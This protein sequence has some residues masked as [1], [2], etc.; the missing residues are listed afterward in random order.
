MPSQ[1]STG[2]VE[3]KPDKSRK[4]QKTHGDTLK[5]VNFC[6]DTIDKQDIKATVAVQA[7][8]LYDSICI[9][10]L[11]ATGLYL[12]TELFPFNAPRCTS[13]LPVFVIALDQVKQVMLS[14]EKKC[15]C[16]NENRTSKKKK[17]SIQQQSLRIYLSN[18]YQDNNTRFYFNIYMCITL[19]IEG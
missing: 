8:G 15:V 18:N 7:V 16:S 12:I 13:E 6:K 14:H 11:E 19:F 5:L 3:V 4:I 2:Y 10:S 17:P 1:L 9:V